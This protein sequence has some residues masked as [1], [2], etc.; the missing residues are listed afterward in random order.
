[1]TLIQALI[2]ATLG[3]C[4]SIYG[5]W[6]FGTVGGWDVVG[7]P[8]VAGAIIGFILGKPTEGIIIGAAV[9][10][11]YIGLVTP[12]LSMPGD[13]NFAAWI[14]IPLAIV[15]SSSPEY[16]VSLA[17]PLSFLGVACVYLVVSVN[18]WF[19]HWQEKLVDQGKLDLAINVPLVAQI[20]NF[21]VRFVPIFL[22]NYYGAGFISNLVKLIPNWLGDIFL[23]LGKMLPAVG[24]GLL[25]KYMLNDKIEILYFLIGFLLISIFK[26]PIIPVVIIAV[27]L[28]YL[29]YKHT[30]K[31]EREYGTH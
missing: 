11:L 14:G 22:A 17:V 23:V 16:A 20:T 1:M 31:K 28:A 4:S 25:I 19:V 10:A 15:S 3:Y 8:L 24:F 2:I 12:G 27:F 6:L 5:P 13:I 21:L 7:R 9:Q 18:V 30:S 26:M 29:D